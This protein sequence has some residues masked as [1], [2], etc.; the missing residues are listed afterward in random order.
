M[1]KTAVVITAPIMT[2]KSVKSYTLQIILIVM[3]KTLF[4]VFFSRFHHAFKACLLKRISRF[5]PY[6]QFL[7][8]SDINPQLYKAVEP[9]FIFS[10][11][12]I[13]SQTTVLM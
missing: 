12:R 2:E 9:L 1:I 11:S 3:I 10:F 5:H 6:F 13:I 8:S 7:F 4:A